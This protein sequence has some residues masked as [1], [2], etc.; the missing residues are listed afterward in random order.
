L[1]TWAGSAGAVD[2]V[3]GPVVDVAHHNRAGAAELSRQKVLPA[4]FLL[5]IGLLCLVVGA[6]GA[7]AAED[8]AKEYGFW[9]GAAAVGLVFGAIGW[10]FFILAVYWRRCAG[11]Q[12]AYLRAGPGGLS[13]RVPAPPGLALS[14]KLLEVDLPWQQIK[15]WKLH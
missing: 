7:A 13:V 15:T 5:M 3:V 9:L 10:L 12:G 1:A 8:L 2:S 14:Y 4:T 6:T 11:E